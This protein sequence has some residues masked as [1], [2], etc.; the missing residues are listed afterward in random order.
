MPRLSNDNP[1][2]K[3]LVGTTKYRP[4][5]TSRPFTSKVAACQW[6]TS[7]VDWYNHLHHQ[8]NNGDALGICRYRTVVY[9]QRCQKNLLRW[10]RSTRCW[11]QP[12]VA[13]INQPPAETELHSATLT[14]ADGTAAGA[15]SFL[16]TTT[17]DVEKGIT[18]QSMS[19]WRRDTRVARRANA[20]RNQ[21]CR[22][23]PQG[24]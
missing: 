6:V 14:M 23:S 19:G 20:D 1:Y 4:E 15:S 16:A 11:H 18:I 5:D 7:F 21:D 2:S 13:W 24:H 3:P 17:K 9:E 12:E 22:N 8:R 10:S